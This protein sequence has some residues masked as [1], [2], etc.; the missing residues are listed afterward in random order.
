[1]SEFSKEIGDSKENKP[2]EKTL[3]QKEMLNKLIDNLQERA[4]KLKK[5]GQEGNYAALKEA[6]RL[7]SIINRLKGR[8]DQI[9]V[10][11]DESIYP[12]KE[13]S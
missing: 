2:E 4:S 10:K 3:T 1:M 7:E 12:N 11:E 8:L 6:L 9:R 5:E 13:T